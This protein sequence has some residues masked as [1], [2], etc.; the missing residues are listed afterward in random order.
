[1]L[2]RDAGGA[3]REP[4]SVRYED[5]A[6]FQELLAESPHLLGL[7]GRPPAVSLREL[8]IPD[9]GYLDLLLV[10]VDG[11]LSLVEVKLNRNA[12][13]RRAVVGQLLGYAGGLT[14]MTYDDLDRAVRTKTG[15]DLVELTAI[16]AADAGTELDRDAFRAAVAT[17]LSSGVFRLVFA[18]D[19]ISQDL[20]RAVEFLNGSTTRDVEVLVLELAYARAG[21]T[22]ILVDRTYGEEGFR[23]KRATQRATWTEADLFAALRELCTDEE[24]AAARRLYDEIAPSAAS[25]FW[26]QGNTP[27]VTLVFSSPE[28]DFQPC[29]FFTT[30]V[31]L[32]FEYTSRRPTA[33]RN[34]MLAA[35]REVP[36]IA[37]LEPA[38]VASGFAKRPTV[39]YAEVAAHTTSFIEA[40]RAIS[41]VRAR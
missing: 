28:G 21:T 15:S 13:I 25:L 32:N 38:I 20:R 23:R 30:G 16:V 29:T 26:G 24:L 7:G 2:I 41:D 3:W 8:S 17:N 9:A 40:I 27:S 37:R 12:E 5:E 1:V 36:T 22:E 6:A 10:H 18:V 11:S 19:E 34:Q 4:D 39:P 35:V 33:A 14:A 31:A